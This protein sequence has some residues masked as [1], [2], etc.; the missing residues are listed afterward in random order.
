MQIPQISIDDFH[1]LTADDHE[2]CS[3]LSKFVEQKLKNVDGT[4][5]TE[6]INGHSFYE[7]KREED[8]QYY[9][10]VIFWE[11]KTNQLTV[12]M[13]ELWLFV[14]NIFLCAFFVWHILHQV[15]NS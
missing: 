8:L 13:S 6:F 14:C 10:E 12:C 4:V 3:S 7:F 2:G 5:P 15:V 1:V 11:T 9:K